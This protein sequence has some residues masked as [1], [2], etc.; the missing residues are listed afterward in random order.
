MKTYILVVSMVT[1]C[2]MLLGWWMVL[3]GDEQGYAPASLLEPIDGSSSGDDD[4]YNDQ[5]TYIY[6][7]VNL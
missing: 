3:V 4:V 2:V 5:G 6:V 1:G 7:C